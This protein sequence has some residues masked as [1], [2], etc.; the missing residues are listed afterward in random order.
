MS[1]V[2]CGSGT[3]SKGTSLQWDTDIK[4]TTPSKAKKKKESGYTCTLN[5]ALFVLTLL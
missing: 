4:I 3:E 5:T 1:T 2:C